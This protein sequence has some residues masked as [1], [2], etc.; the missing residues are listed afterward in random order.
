MS[1][2]NRPKLPAK[3]A[4]K[5]AKY[6]G[7]EKDTRKATELDEDYV[8]EATPPPPK[9][10]KL[11]TIKKN[12]PPLQT[13]DSNPVA[14]APAA[15]TEKPPPPTVPENFADT[16]PLSNPLR[17]PPP[18]NEFDL[19]NPAQYAELFKSVRCSVFL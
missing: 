12:K 6:K 19:R 13:E 11:P 5:G 15:S 18:K 14:P 17:K 7:N 16:S 10:R 3:T 4:S 9:K 2:T 8:E 1:T